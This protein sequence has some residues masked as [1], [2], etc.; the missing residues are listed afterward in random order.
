MM[1]VKISQN[2]S[3]PRKYKDVWG[4]LVGNDCEVINKDNNFLICYIEIKIPFLIV[5]NTHHC[6][7]IFIS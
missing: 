6:Y 2:I 7:I 5:N 3:V 4:R 1:V